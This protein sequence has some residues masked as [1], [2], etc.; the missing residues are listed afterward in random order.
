MLYHIITVYDKATQA[1][2]RPFVA[3][4]TGQAVRMF[5][6]E[7]QAQGS[8]IGKHPEDYA[9]FKI[10]TFND[11]SGEVAGCEPFCLRRAHEIPRQ[12][13]A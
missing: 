4:S 12:A 7:T 1:Y 13:Q 11:S 9:L 2:M 6:D 10:G 8:E 3:L 5:E